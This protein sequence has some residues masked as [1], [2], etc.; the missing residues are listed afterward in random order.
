MLYDLNNSAMLLGCFCRSPHLTLSDKYKIDSNDFKCPNIEESKFYDV[1][2]RVIYNLAR[3]GAKEVDGV[4]L[5]MFLQEYPEQLKLCSQYNH[6]DFVDTIRN[7]ANL[8]NIELYYTIVR[9]YAMLREYKSKGFDVS[10][11]YD[12]LKDDASQKEN[13]SRY[14]LSDIAEHFNAMQIEIKQKYVLSGDVEH[15]RLADN[16]DYAFECFQNGT[17][18]GLSFSDT[19]LNRLSYGYTG[20]TLVSGDTGSGKSM[21]AVGNVCKSACEYLYNYETQQYEKNISFCGNALFINTELKFTEQLQPMFLAYVSGV[22]RSKIRQWDLTP[23]EESRVRKAGEIIGQHLFAVDLPEFTISKIEETIDYYVERHNI[24]VVA[25]DYLHFNYQLGAEISKQG[26]VSNRED[27]CLNELSRALK[28]CSLKHNIPVLTGTQLNRNSREKRQPDSTWLSGG[29]SQEFKADA[30]FIITQ[31]TKEDMADLEAY[32]SFYTDETAPTHCIHAIKARDSK[33]PK[34]T[35][36][37]T[38]IDLGT[39]R[40]HTLFCTD[41]NMELLDVKPMEINYLDN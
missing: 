21:F 15:H 35:R 16:L 3:Q 40:T 39:G 5:D 34:G 2:Y 20:L 28:N 26:S 38:R 12:E 9:K 22:E 11:I 25:F 1:V 29:L 24:K 7:V 4:A 13:L 19:Y 41:K 37:Y 18:T 10:Q 30:V 36:V 31:I 33:Y 8:D 27:M 14:S 23:E 6:M 17:T 32:Q